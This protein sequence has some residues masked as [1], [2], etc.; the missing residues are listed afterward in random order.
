MSILSRITRGIGYGAI[1]VASFGLLQ[2]SSSQS[3]EP[4]LLNNNNG[5]YAHTLSILDI[6]GGRYYGHELKQKNKK[7]KNNN[8]QNFEDLIPLQNIP[9][10]YDN[11][12]NTYISS[13]IVNNLLVNNEILLINNDIQ[14]NDIKLTAN[15]YNNTND[16]SYLSSVSINKVISTINKVIPGSITNKLNAKNTILSNSVSFDYFINSNELFNP[17][18]ELLELEQSYI[19]SNI[20]SNQ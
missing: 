16:F 10:Y 14:Y 20:L 3:I 7:H 9:T 1:A 13:N 11:V 18:I 19:I 17:S 4:S 8:K 2:S 15:V 6:S 12:L 5:F